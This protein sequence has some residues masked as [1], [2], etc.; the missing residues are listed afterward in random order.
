MVGGGV[1]L[2]V[3]LPAV[4]TLILSAGRVGGGALRPATNAQTRPL[5]LSLAVFY[6]LCVLSVYHFALLCSVYCR[7]VRRA[8]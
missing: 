8:A 1:D 4:P 7:A 3:F 6:F 2:F 5:S